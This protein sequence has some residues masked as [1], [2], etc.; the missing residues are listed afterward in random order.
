MKALI[1]AAGLGTR[2]GLLTSSRPK[3]MLTIAGR[4]LLEHTVRLLRTHGVRDIAINIH[5]HPET[6][7]EHF[8]DG[9]AF[10][11]RLVYSREERLMGTAGAVKRLEHFLDEPFFVIYGDVL[12]DMDLSRL[13]AWHRDRRAVLSLALYRV[14]DPTRAGIV[15]VDADGRV[16]RFQEKPA[17]EDVFSD[18]ANTGI[19]V[20]EP[21]MLGSVPPDTFCDFGEHVIPTLLN[22]RARV[23]GRLADAYVLDIGSPERY[24]LALDDA[25]VGRVRLHSLD[26][27]A[28]VLL[29]D[30]P[31]TSG[32]RNPC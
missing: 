24:A 31:A 7:V 4:P 25:R 1:L 6:I 17:A 5:H 15:D 27:V 18:L 8:R 26:E 3:P 20:A 9:H 22:R 23:Y 21:E 12:T 28:G 19:I 2:L 32:D 10:G 14:E 29:T 16:Q 13:A 30:Q 11:V